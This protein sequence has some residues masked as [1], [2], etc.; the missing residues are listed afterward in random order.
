MYV[1]PNVPGMIFKEFKIRDSGKDHFH[2]L[3]P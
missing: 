3:A 2:T 1:I